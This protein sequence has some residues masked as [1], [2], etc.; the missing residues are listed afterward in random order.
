L[1]S[2]HTKKAFQVPCALSVGKIA[3]KPSIGIAIYPKDG[4][5]AGAL[6]KSADA[7]MY[8]AKRNKSGYCFAP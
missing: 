8:Q 3:I 2:S 7:G 1:N 6:L 5:S 4:S